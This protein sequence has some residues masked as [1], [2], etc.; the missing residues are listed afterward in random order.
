MASRAAILPSVAGLLVTALWTAPGATAEEAMRV[1]D[2]GLVSSQATC[3]ETAEKVLS[4]YIAEFGGLA[5]SGDPADPQE[6]AIYGWGLRPGTNDVVI[7]CPTVMGNTNAF[8]SVHSAGE[9]PAADA[10]TVAERLRE[11]WDQQY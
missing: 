11:L 6:W 7:I 5:T 2:L 3:L 1:G 9:A 4:A 8:Y 10:D